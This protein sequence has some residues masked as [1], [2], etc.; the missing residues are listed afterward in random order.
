MKVVGEASDGKSL[1]SLL[2]KKECD[3]IL[4]DLS[5][6]KLSG[7]EALEIIKRDYPD[8]KILI[9]TMYHEKNYFKHVMQKGADGFMLKTEMFTSLLEAMNKII[10]GVAVFYDQ[11]KFSPDETSSAESLHEDKQI[12]VFQEALDNNEFKVLY[13]PIFSLSNDKMSSLEALVRWQKANNEILT[14][15]VFLEQAESTGEIRAIGKMVLYQAVRQLKKWHDM[16]H[17]E[18]SVS[19]NFSPLQFECS[20]VITDIKEILDETRINPEKLRVEITES[21]AM[22]DILFAKSVFQKLRELGVTILMDDF[23]VG[24]SS[25]KYIQEFPV[26]GLKIDRY[27]IESM[28]NNQINKLLTESIITMAKNLNLKTV[29]EGVENLVQLNIL[30]ELK[31]E[32][33][34]GYYFSKPLESSEIQKILDKQNET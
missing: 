16:G 7:L 20:Q 33:V 23:G 3:L 17:A 28:D 9:L 5:M 22:K 27:F 15:D 6:P 19:V 12:R 30:R 2:E 1:L 24:H 10:S 14:P 25:L 34:Q 4:L 32:E 13:Q 26:H 8:I 29:A 18:L 11:N 31:C 21:L